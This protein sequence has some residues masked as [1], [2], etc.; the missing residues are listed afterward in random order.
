MGNSC[1]GKS[2]T[3]SIINPTSEY[4]AAINAEL[5][6]FLSITSPYNVN[7]KYAHFFK[8]I[9]DQKTGAGIKQTHPYISKLTLQE[10]QA[11]RVEFWDTRVEGEPKAWRALR[12]ACETDN[13]EIAVRTLGVARVKLVNQSLQLAYDHRGHKYDVPIFCIH[14]PADYDI[15]LKKELRKEEVAEEQLI[16][17]MR[18]PGMV[19]DIK[20][21]ICNNWTV[22]QMKE[23]FL[24][25]NDKE[26][27]PSMLRLFFSG[28]ELHDN[29]L[30]AD[31]SIQNE[32]VIQVIK[33]KA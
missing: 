5:A 30:I 15:P 6:P 24:K 23:E 11:K 9:K 8:I 17:K 32:H 25:Q 1:C 3:L 22:L 16:V 26:R 20:L 4:H 33:K 18:V 31:Y 21:Q 29:N 14:D 2:S 7:H 28:K 13:Q 12:E 10:I 27:D 19:N